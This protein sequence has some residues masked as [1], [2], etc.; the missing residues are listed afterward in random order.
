MRHWSNPAAILLGTSARNSLGTSAQMAGDAYCTYSVLDNCFSRELQ[1]G[2]VRTSRCEVRPLSLYL[3]RCH[4]L[5][6]ASSGLRAL[7]CPT[8]VINCG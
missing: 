5:L 8:S 3:P 1:S 4:D 6:T 2:I 7:R